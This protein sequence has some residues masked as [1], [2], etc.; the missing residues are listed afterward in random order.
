MLKRKTNNTGAHLYIV[1]KIHI[2]YIY[3]KYCI[4]KYYTVS[5]YYI[6]VCFIALRLERR[7]WADL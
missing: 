6:K 4:N 3:Q 2:L 5:K 1:N 7:S